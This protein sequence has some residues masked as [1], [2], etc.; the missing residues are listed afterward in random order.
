VGLGVLVPG[1]GCVD[2][3]VGCGVWGVCVGADVG[4]GVCAG[5]D[6]CAGVGACVCAGADVGAGLGVGVCVCA[7]RLCSASSRPSM[8]ASSLSIASL[9]CTRTISPLRILSA[10]DEPDESS[11]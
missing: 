9:S 2:V 5:A 7:S 11:V 4:A 1:V 10:S 3:C 8:E 6:V